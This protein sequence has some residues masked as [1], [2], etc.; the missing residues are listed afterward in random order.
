MKARLLRLAPASPAE[1]LDA[2][3]DTAAGGGLLIFPTDTVYGLGARADREEPVRRVYAAKGRPGELAL[4]IL[5]G[6]V[7]G[8]RRVAQWSEAAQ[9]LAEEF[10]PGPLT[11]VL[12]H[13]LSRLCPLVTGGRE[14]VGVRRPDC[15][16]LRD[17]LE[18]CDFPLAV[19]SANR[20]GEPP[21]VH[22]AQLPPELLA[23]ADLLL[24]G[25]PAP[26]G[27]PS[28]VV[29]L[30]CTPPRVLRPGPVS[31][32]DLRAALAGCLP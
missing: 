25:G 30:T 22:P 17:W 8:A 4:P 14:T 23:A 9:R 28:T 24:D 18:A 16:A 6:S 10:W 15:E 11:L 7:E 12:E 3:R 32:Q 31:E 26:G 19:T 1:A 2:F 21:A 29:D 20:S 5:V 13:R 27:V